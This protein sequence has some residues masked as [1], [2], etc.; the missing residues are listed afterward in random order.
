MG[1]VFDF[2]DASAYEKWFYSPGNRITADREARLIFDM[3][4]PIRGRA[5]LDI[6]CGT[7]AR[8]AGFVEKGLDVSGLDPSPYM[9]DIAREKFKN[10]VEFFRNFGESLPF[11]DN[12]FHYATL[13]TTL[14]YVD[15]PGKV[16]EEACR[17]T[18]DKIF[19]GIY[20]RY[21]LK[22]IERRVKALFSDSIYRH[23]RFYS[24]WEIKQ[25]IQKVIGNVSVTWKTICWFPGSFEKYML[26]MEDAFIMQKIP[27]GAFA[28]IVIM[29]VPRFRTTPLAL[30]YKTKHSAVHSI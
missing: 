28:G 15:D 11:E 23:A 24:V 2:K 27:F 13:I 18:K 4:K 1:Y 29:P 16:I 26:R 3:L 25:I 8:L 14:E 17:V 7:G 9:L 10:R 21:A 30:K 6:G 22:C 20:N 12:S 5:L 19:I